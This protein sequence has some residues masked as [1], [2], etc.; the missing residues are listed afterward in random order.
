[1][2]ITTSHKQGG[3][4]IKKEQEERRLQVFHLHFEEKKSA[5]E[6]AKLLNKNRNTIDSD[7]KYLFQKIGSELNVKD[8][9]TIT[10][11]QILKIEIQ[12][13]RLLEN[14]DESE[15]LDQKIKLEKVISEIDDKLFNLHSKIIL[16]KESLAHKII[17]KPIEKDEVKDFVKSLILSD[18]GY[19]SKGIFSFNEIIFHLIHEKEYD[20]GYSH[21][22]ILKMDSLGLNLCI[23]NTF[24]E[25]RDLNAHIFDNSQQYD[26]FRFA[27]MCN[28][29]TSDEFKKFIDN[30]AVYHN[31]TNNDK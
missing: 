14:L 22:V 17:T 21:R 26:L 3:R 12:K 6:I 31:P 28:F 1:M 7:I 19:D 2:I 24:L 13:E 4:Y 23:K 5:V 15:N 29:I 18:V 30:T 25:D 9:I 16:H 27:Y 11:E 8:M 20:V 10:N